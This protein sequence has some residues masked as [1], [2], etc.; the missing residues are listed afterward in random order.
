MRTSHFLRIDC[1]LVVT[2]LSSVQFIFAGVPSIA[3]GRTVSDVLTTAHDI[4]MIEWT[5]GPS[6]LEAHCAKR[7]LPG[8]APT[9][10]ENPTQKQRGVPYK[11]GG[12]DTEGCFTWKH[13]ALTG[14]GTVSPTEC[15][16]DPID[17]RPLSAALHDITGY[18]KCDACT[19]GVDCSGLVSAAWGL[20]GHVATADLVKHGME[21]KLTESNWLADLQ[22]GDAL[23]WQNEHV[24]HAAIV[25]HVMMNEQNGSETV[26]I[27]DAP[28]RVTKPKKGEDSKK[29][30]ERN[31]RYRPMSWKD[32]LSIGAVPSRVRYNGIV[33]DKDIPRTYQCGPPHGEAVV[34]VPA[35]RAGEGKPSQELKQTPRAVKPV[36][37]GRSKKPRM[38]PPTRTDQRDQGGRL[39][40]LQQT[41]S[42]Q[43]AP[44]T[45]AESGT[46]DSKSTPEKVVGNDDEKV[47]STAPV[48]GLQEPH[49]AHTP[50]AEPTGRRQDS[51]PKAN[52]SRQ[53]RHR[54]W[55]WRL[56]PWHWFSHR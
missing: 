53:P 16:Q 45:S 29:D 24:Q 51:P 3:G 44:S 56:L 14:R 54:S 26:C 50:D 32:L 25:D 30:T 6:D 23:L 7:L 36:K 38:P 10:W 5:L 46:Q 15:S 37:D 42:H 9:K 40:Q 43:A 39:Q 19:T 11:W 34:R 27:V 49:P 4:A 1:L 33:K 18:K 55:V 8:A 17:T 41:P 22:P 12:R 48:A 31:A 35:G 21:Q 2:I 47:P 52:P 28:G 13:S 20:K